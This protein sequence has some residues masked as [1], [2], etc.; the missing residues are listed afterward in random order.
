MARKDA[1]LERDLRMSTTRAARR[2]NA[3]NALL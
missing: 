2:K 1:A 3:N